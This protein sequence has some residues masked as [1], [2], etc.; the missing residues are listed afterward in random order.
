[1]GRT[2]GRESTWDVVLPGKRLFESKRRLSLHHPEAGPMLALS[3]MEDT[4]D[5]L[6]GSALVRG[7][8]LVT[9]DSDLLGVG[10][11]YGCTTMPDP[12]RSLDSALTQGLRGTEREVQR[13]AYVVADLPCL[14]ARDVDQV[15][16]AAEAAG[17]AVVP[18]M[19]ERGTTFLATTRTGGLK[20]QFGIRSFDAHVTA[21]ATPVGLDVSRARHDVDT[22]ADLAVA[23]TLGLGSRSA[24]VVGSIEAKGCS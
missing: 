18:D 4:L 10:K 2:G 24:A 12:D 6:R 20:P 8:V 16:L 5:A 21:G 23:R 15:L 17:D 3:M 9:S 14:T 11:R 13:V 19:R 1:M 7:I 22:W